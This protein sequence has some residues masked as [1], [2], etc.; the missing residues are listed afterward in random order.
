MESTTHNQNSSQE[1]QSTLV[2]T[3]EMKDLLRER[4]KQKKQEM[5]NFLRDTA[6]SIEPESERERVVEKIESF[7]D[8][9][10]K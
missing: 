3:E 4:T 7:I 8:T 2:I 9:F 10:L 1:T 5:V 6:A